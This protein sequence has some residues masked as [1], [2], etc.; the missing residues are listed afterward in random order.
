MRRRVIS[1]EL[2]E[3]CP[4]LLDRWMADGSLP[5]FRRLHDG[6]QVYRTE[7]DVDSPDQ[8][9]PWIQWYSIHTGL[10][11]AQHGVFHLT[12]GRRAEH[13][14]IW[15][16]LIAAGRSVISFASMNVRPFAAPGS[17][18]VGDPWIEAGD[19]HPGELNVYNR[20]IGHNVREYTNK[21][22]LGAAGYAA[23]L[24]FLVSHGLTA[25]TAWGTIRQLAQEQLKNHLSYRRVAILDALQFDVFAHY[26]RASKPEFAS[27][28]VN[29]VA[30]LQHSYWRHMEPEAFTLR[31]SA[32]ELERYGDAI[33]FGYRAMDGL[34]GRFLRLAERHDAT[35]VLQTA[36]SQQPFTRHED[37]G[38]QHFHRLHDVE[39]FLRDVGIVCRSAAPTMTHQYMLTFDSEAE[40]SAARA[41]LEDFE[42]EDGRS[43][44]DF[45]E[46]DTPLALYFGA[47]INWAADP[48]TPIVDRRTG[49]RMAL[50]DI[51]YAID[52]TKSGC[53][54]PIG[55]LWIQTG[56]HRRHDALVSILD[57]F[58]TLLDLL[59]G[60]AA[61][62]QRRGKSLLARAPERAKAA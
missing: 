51:L 17:I 5:N 38:G 60:E 30:H 16:L 23:F 13:E 48:A 40:R 11:Y 28:F 10:A 9:E 61:R 21:A 55:A 20:F 31:P 32:K 18:Y 29:S 8:L 36:L 34:V 50:G 45:P 52:G 35:L 27:F 25:Q 24:R 57:I 58:P 6:S 15:R 42:V 3:L 53:H 22:P 41:R 62:G 46:H 1:L 12:D 39:A 37:R 7:A 43:V 47:Q 19:A 59:G 4:S 26:Y 14:D 2:N 56:S 44:F 33:A 54:N 49:R